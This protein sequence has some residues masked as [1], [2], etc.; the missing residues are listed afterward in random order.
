MTLYT[1]FESRE[2]QVRE[3]AAQYVATSDTLVAI[4]AQKTKRGTITLS[5]KLVSID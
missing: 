2:V 1:N 4:E 5:K 3:V